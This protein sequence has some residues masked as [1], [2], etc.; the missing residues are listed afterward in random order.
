M[1]SKKK[2][3]SSEHSTPTSKLRGEE[4]KLKSE[5][6]VEEMLVAQVEALLKETATLRD[7]LENKRVPEEKV[8]E[9]Q[10]LLAGALQVV[11]PL[12]PIIGPILGLV[13]L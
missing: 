12:L 5:S 6:K 13:G 8:P 9:A 4:D 10:G 1:A 3:R 11:E 7:A 2:S